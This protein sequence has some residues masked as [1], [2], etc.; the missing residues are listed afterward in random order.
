MNY[1]YILIFWFLTVCLTSLSLISMTLLRHKKHALIKLL[2]APKQLKLL[3]QPNYSKADQFIELMQNYHKQFM[4]HD[5]TLPKGIVNLSCY[6]FT[7]L[8]SW[9]YYHL[10]KYPGGTLPVLPVSFTYSDPRAKYTCN[11][12]DGNSDKN[13]KYIKQVFSILKPLK[14]EIDKGIRY[15]VVKQ[16]EA[17]ITAKKRATGRKKAIITSEV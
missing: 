2:N 13:L 9:L 11:F 12:Y 14:R 15:D 7:Y 3:P 6:D 5:D 4:R 17:V 1:E 16:A 10:T 8:R